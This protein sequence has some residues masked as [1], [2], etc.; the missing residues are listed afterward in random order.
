[1]DIDKDLEQSETGSDSLESE[2]DALSKIIDTKD[3]A[4]K[5]DDFKL[6]SNVFPNDIQF[7]S[8]EDNKSEFVADDNLLY[9]EVLFGEKSAASSSQDITLTGLKEGKFYTDTPISGA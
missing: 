6:D 3:G 7:D 8:T 4:Q 5:L 1:M 2:I 9:K